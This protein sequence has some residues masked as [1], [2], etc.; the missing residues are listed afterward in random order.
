MMSGAG[1]FGFVMAGAGVLTMVYAYLDHLQKQTWQSYL[2]LSKELATLKER[3]K[4][5]AYVYDIRESYRSS[6]PE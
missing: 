6:I 5:L 4:E 1:L 2:D 3:Q